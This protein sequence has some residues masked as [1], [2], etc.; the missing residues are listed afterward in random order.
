MLGEGAD[1]L[2]D[3]ERVQAVGGERGGAE[4]ARV[5]GAERVRLGARVGEVQL[6]DGV[7][8]RGV[9]RRRR[10]VAAGGERE[11]G[12]EYG[13]RA[14]QDSGTEASGPLRIVVPR[15]SIWRRNS[16]LSR[17]RSGL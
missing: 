15:T 13:A 16:R 7:D 10:V 14:A 12:A 8:E 5:V 2:G 17:L 3:V 4:R 9:D 6:G 1:A 11:R